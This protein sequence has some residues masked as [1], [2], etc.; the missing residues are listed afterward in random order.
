MNPPQPLIE[1]IHFFK[2]QP[3]KVVS[4]LQKIWLL[5]MLLNEE[6]YFQHLQR[7][8]AKLLLVKPYPL[9]AAI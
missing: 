2:I 7:E 9:P 8:W 6:E 3:A 1:T 5:T 4:I